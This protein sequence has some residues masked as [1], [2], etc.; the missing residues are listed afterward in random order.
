MEKRIVSLHPDDTLSADRL[1]LN[2]CREGFL[3]RLVYER[4]FFLFFFHFF[5]LCMCV[6]GHN[7]SDIVGSYSVHAY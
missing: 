1:L 5:L 3:I 4:P 7:S 6:D 2:N